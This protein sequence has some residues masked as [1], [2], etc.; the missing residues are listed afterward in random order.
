MNILNFFK[1]NW[2]AILYFNFKML[3]FKQAIKLP[4]DFWGK[5]KFVNLSG[6]VILDTDDIRRGM[7]CIGL[8]HST[9][10]PSYTSTINFSGNIKF[11]GT[12]NIG[13][14]IL[15][16]INKNSTVSI[17][18]NVEIGGLTK[19]MCQKKI[20]ISDNISISWECQIL[21]SDFHFIRDIE[22]NKIK[23][24]KMDVLIGNNVWLG[25]R[26]TINKG[27]VLPDFTIIAS[28]SVC[29]KDYSKGGNNHIIIAGTPAKV[30]SEGYERVF[31]A[32]EPEL[33]KQLIKNEN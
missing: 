33:I 25:N 7:I 24:R 28:N 1:H 14:G 16:E 29:N 9:L 20:I 4:F 8:N 27:T 32:L 31:E 22:T 3:P 26:V 5:V 30:V 11:R 15:I 19:I 21:D 18:N 12:A 6:K 23:P 2:P 13:R 17:G 10:F